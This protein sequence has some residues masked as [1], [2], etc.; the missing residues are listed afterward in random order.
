MFFDTLWNYFRRSNKVEQQLP[1]ERQSDVNLI[2]TLKEKLLDR[3]KEF[4]QKGQEF[5]IK[6]DAGGDET[7]VNFQLDGEYF[8][9]YSDEVYIDFV[10]YLIEEF[11]LP[12][13]GEYYNE[14][15]GTLSIEDGDSLIFEYSEYAY[16]EDYLSEEDTV[17]Y[18]EGFSIT[19]DESSI[20]LLEYVN[21]ESM[22]FYGSVCFL[23]E[24]TE[25]FSIYS[26][27]SDK[28]FKKQKVPELHQRIQAAVLAKFTPPFEG[29]EINYVGN[30]NEEYILIEELHT[31]QYFIDKNFKDAKK[32]LFD[33][34]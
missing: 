9:H 1:S 19:A 31:V 24:Q 23:N 10:R 2:P 33:A 11:E 15:G 27:L 14:G 21:E 7:L 6:W 26:K 30:L 20:K 32:Y 8:D 13:A 18:R 4:E 28:R 17:H 29:I 12:N 5:S 22:N 25:D 16:G 3:L 34:S